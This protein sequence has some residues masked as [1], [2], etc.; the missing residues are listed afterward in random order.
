MAK[1]FAKRLRLL[2]NDKKGKYEPVIM[3]ILEI[4]TLKKNFVAFTSS[5]I[6]SRVGHWKKLQEKWNETT[7]YNSNI[8][9]KNKP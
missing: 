1:K 8:I 7:R 3:T 6:N 5:N 4:L 2:K 9:M